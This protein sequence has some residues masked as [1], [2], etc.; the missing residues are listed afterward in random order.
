VIVPFA[1]WLMRNKPGHRAG[2]IFH[3][4]Q[5]IFLVEKKNRIFAVKNKM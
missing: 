4:F 5:N 3:F 1:L 2:L